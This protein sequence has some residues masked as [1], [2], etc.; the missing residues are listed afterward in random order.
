MTADSLMFKL[1]DETSSTDY[2]NSEAT[3]EEVEEEY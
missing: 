2:N 1:D 3:Q